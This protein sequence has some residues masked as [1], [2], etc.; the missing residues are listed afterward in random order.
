LLKELKVFERKKNK[1]TKDWKNQVNMSYYNKMCNIYLTED[2]VKF[3][4]PP[5]RLGA[6]EGQDL[7]RDLSGSGLGPNSDTRKHNS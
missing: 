3:I 7:A 2:S 6:I 1:I 4:I 5:Y